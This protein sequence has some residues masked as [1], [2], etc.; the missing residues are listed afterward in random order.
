[1]SAGNGI[2]LNSGDTIQNLTGASDADLSLPDLNTAEIRIDGILPVIREEIR[3]DTKIF[4]VRERPSS[5][6]VGDFNSDD[7]PDLAIANSTSNTVSILLGD[8]SGGSNSQTAF[9]T[10]LNP[11]SLGVADFD[12]DSKLDLAIANEGSQTVSLLL[13]NGD[14]SF[15]SQITFATGLNPQSLSVADFDGD[16]KLDLAIANSGDGTVSLLLGNGSGFS[17]QMTFAVGDAPN[18]MS[19]GDFNGDGKPDLA[20]SNGVGE[21]VSVLLNNSGMNNGGNFSNRSTLAAGS[22][23]RAITVGDFNRDGRQDLAIAND[24]SVGTV[25]VFLGNGSAG[26]SDRATFATGKAQ[27][28]ALLVGDFSG[29][30]WTDL[31]VLHQDSNAVSLLLGD[32]EGRF[33]IRSIFATG[34]A[35]TAIDVGDFDVYQVMETLYYC[36]QIALSMMGRRIALSIVQSIISH[37][38]IRSP[39]PSKRS[40][41]SGTPSPYTQQC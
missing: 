1:M 15:R 8:G 29:D 30:Q 38:K 9:A 12:G 11:Q 10:E 2:V 37:S 24:D 33:N 7:K 40:K 35:P 21:T 5:V 28:S 36:S 23:L 20:I 22:H 4:A 6:R 27:P 26:F 32:G 14:G 16:G 34:S 39:L 31:A 13:G 19:S 17:P 25:S 18:A 41:F 3:T